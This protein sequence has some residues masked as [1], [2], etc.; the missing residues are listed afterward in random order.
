MN[1]FMSAYRRDM[2]EQTAQGGTMAEE[3]ISSVRNVRTIET[4]SHLTECR[5]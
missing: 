1:R 4:T 3:A 5:C 2:L